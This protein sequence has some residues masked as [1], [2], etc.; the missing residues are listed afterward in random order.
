[1]SAPESTAD[2]G[3]DYTVAVHYYSQ[4]DRIDGFMYGALKAFVR[5]FINGELVWDFNDDGQGGFKTL[6]AEG[7]F[8]E[9][10]TISWDPSINIGE[11]TTRDVYY[12]M[13]PE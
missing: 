3:G 6:E 4:R 1:M 8:W 9:A 13:V 10:A 2:L 7:H 12:E 5:I 11:V